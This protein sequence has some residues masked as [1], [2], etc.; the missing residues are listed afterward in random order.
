MKFRVAALVLSMGLAA[1]SA[2]A[3]WATT[4]VS[5]TA[6]FV[7]SEGLVIA[8]ACANADPSSTQQAQRCDIAA[9]APVGTQIATVTITG[10]PTAYTG[11]PI[12]TE[13]T[14]SFVLQG[15]AS[16]FSIVT[17]V[18]PLTQPNYSVNIDASQ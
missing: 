12:F 8:L 10:I 18:S 1:A 14:G 11:M 13:A 9:S 6:T 5:V 17:T 4:T 2:W 16:P 15:T 3:A 7:V